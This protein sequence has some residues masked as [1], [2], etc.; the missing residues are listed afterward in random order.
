MP[1]ETAETILTFSC[2]VITPRRTVFITDK[3]TNA[4]FAATSGELEIQPRHEPVLSPLKIGHLR[5]FELQSNGEVKEVILNINGGFLDMNGQ[6][7]TVFAYSAETAEEIDAERAK[8]AEKRARERLDEIARKTPQAEKIDA[9]R[10]E[11]ALFRAISR[12]KLHNLPI[13]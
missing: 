5:L 2:A 12:L 4:V 7:A 3:V 9:E 13:A 8:A 1:D 11:R 6:Q 10:A